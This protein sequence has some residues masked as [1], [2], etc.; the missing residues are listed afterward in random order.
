M[1]EEVVHPYNMMRA[2]KQV[3]RN[4]GSAGVDGMRVGELYDYYRTNRKAIVESVRGGTYLP[5][6]ILGVEIPKGGGKM[7]RIGVPVVMDRMLQQALGQVLCGRY[8]M[9]FE[10]YSYGFRPN[11]NAHQAVLRAEGYT[12]V[13]NG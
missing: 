5:K 10:E 11:R 3:V 2:L 1:I 8:D 4:K 7:H 9:E 6:P 12:P 13:N